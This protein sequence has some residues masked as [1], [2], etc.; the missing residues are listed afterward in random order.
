M[1]VPTIDSVKNK[2]ILQN[3]IINKVN[4]L[5]IGITGTGKTVLTN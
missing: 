3:C 2:Y 5:S 4:T 1:L